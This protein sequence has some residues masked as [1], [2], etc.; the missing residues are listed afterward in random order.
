MAVCHLVLPHFIVNSAGTL[1]EF[2]E[3][4]GRLASIQQRDIAQ[5]TA[6]LAHSLRE[7]KRNIPAAEQVGGATAR[8][9]STAQMVMEAVKC[10]PWPLSRRYHPSVFLFFFDFVHVS[11]SDHEFESKIEA[12]CTSVPYDTAIILHATSGWPQSRLW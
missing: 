6:I 7:A 4:K 12:L 2:A 8:F 11:S 10:A 1:Q 9:K 3:I 5:H